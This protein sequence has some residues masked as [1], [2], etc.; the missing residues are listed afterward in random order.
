MTSE[1]AFQPVHA[2][3]DLAAMAELTPAGFRERFRQTP[4]WRAK[5]SGW[6]RNVAT[7]MGN[8]GDRRYA[9]ALKYLSAHE[10]EAVAEHA[11][12]ALERL[13]DAE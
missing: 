6:L 10:D 3:L 8:S 1:P 11:R 5:Y 4:I 9:D 7:A 12:W 2:L 13:G